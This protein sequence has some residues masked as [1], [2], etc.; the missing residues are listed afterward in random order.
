VSGSVGVV[1]VHTVLIC[2]VMR[3]DIL[4]GAGK[5]RKLIQHHPGQD[6]LHLP[7]G[8]SPEPLLDGW[9][10]TFLKPLFR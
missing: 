4:E 5:H 1:D 8:I 7:S 3:D 6:V 10:K 9:G 2:L